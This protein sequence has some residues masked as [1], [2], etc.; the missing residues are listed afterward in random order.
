MRDGDVMKCLV[1]TLELAVDTG[2]GTR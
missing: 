2:R 1:L